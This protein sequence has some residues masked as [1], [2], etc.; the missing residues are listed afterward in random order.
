MS[1]ERVC[2]NHKGGKHCWHEY[3]RKS[4]KGRYESS[5]PMQCC[6]CDDFAVKREHSADWLE[7]SGDTSTGNAP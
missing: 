3:G 2:P 4:F 7:Y 6:H 1:D 5:S